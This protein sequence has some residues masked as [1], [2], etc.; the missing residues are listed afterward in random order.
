M[1]QEGPR[2]KNRENPNRQQPTKSSL[3]LRPSP[4]S[5]WH[6]SLSAMWEPGVLRGIFLHL[7]V[8]SPRPCTHC[9]LFTPGCSMMIK[10]GLLWSALPL[11]TSIS[12]SVP[13]ALGKR[14]VP[15]L[16]KCWL[17]L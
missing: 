11:T 17:G 7:K 9:I 1:I 3:S 15:Q 10:I 8:P 13:L 14:D 16:G 2:I 4:C 6:L 5:H 12:I